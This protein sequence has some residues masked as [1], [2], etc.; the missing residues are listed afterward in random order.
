MDSIILCG[1]Q[2][3]RLKPYFPFN[4]ALAEIKP[5]YTLIE[6]QV[7]WLTSLGVNHIIAAINKETYQKLE[8]K[9]SP[10]LDRLTYSIEEK[11][12]GTG[13]AV[14]KATK[15]I[16]SSNFYVMNVDDILISTTYTP[17][18][19]IANLYHNSDAVGSIL[20]GKTRFPFG[21]VETSNNKVKGF[22]Q[23]PWL[24]Y[25]VCLGHYAFTKEGVR[26]YFPQ[27]GN[28]EDTA[29][30]N[31]A[32]TNIL[33]YVEFDGEWITVNNIKQLEHLQQKLHS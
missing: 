31:M 32:V 33:Y 16:K 2:S 10:S 18:N 24:T 8:E 7:E 9:R 28:F 19:L 12:L 22:K 26:K 13:G 29:L 3:K 17:S 1:G 23:K 20:V 21:I 14:L 6:Y 25:K 30:P 27:K 15:Y 5:S 4:K 11:R